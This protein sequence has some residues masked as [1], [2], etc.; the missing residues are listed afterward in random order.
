MVRQGRAEEVS[1]IRGHN[2][3]HAI[4]DFEEII[5]DIDESINAYSGNSNLNLDLDKQVEDNE[6]RMLLDVPVLVADSTHNESEWRKDKMGLVTHCEAASGCEFQVGWT[7]GDKVKVGGGVGS[8]KSGERKRGK[9]KQSH[10]SAARTQ[11]SN[12]NVVGPKKSTWTRIP[13]TV[14]SKSKGCDSRCGPKRKNSEQ[15]KEVEEASVSIKKFRMDVVALPVNMI[16]QC[17]SVEV[18][19]QSH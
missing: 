14:Q 9:T 17:L 13:T 18:A 1:I 16:N 19:L 6:E 2:S 11:D 12:S 10:A 8:N 7:S 15:T 3:E 5:R 4:P